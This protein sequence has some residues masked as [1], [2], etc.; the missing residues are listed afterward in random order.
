MK[1]KEVLPNFLV[2]GAAKAGTTSIYRYLSQHPEVYMSPI[3]EPKFFTSTGL[4]F[5][6][7]GPGD[8]MV[9][10]GIVRD[11][12]SYKALFN[13]VDNQKAVGEASADNLYYY[14]IAIP[15]IYKYIRETRIIIILRNP[16]ERAYSAYLHL[17]RDGRENLGFKEALEAEDRRKKNNWEFIW[18][19][20]DVGY[21]YSQ[22]KA[23]LDA[24]GQDKVRIYF[25]EQLKS[26]ALGLMQDIYRFIGVRDDFI[27]Q[28]RRYNV[29]G[30][31][32]SQFINRLLSSPSMFKRIIKRL[33][34]EKAGKDLSL[35]LRRINLKK[36]EMEPELK[37]LLTESYSDD[38]RLLGKLV[39]RD[40][41]HWYT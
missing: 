12:S 17:V 24:F 32:R 14:F 1:G 7:N 35:A 13:D 4:K 26:D 23:Y 11:F 38:I 28:I 3:K 21:Y 40:L 30:I 10:A 31:Q 37:E 22:V 15:N 2:V 34:P 6:H 16:V 27:P 5:P 18:F 41:S 29:S 9:D 39:G 19:Y 8:S 20:K 36:P 33:L 25:F